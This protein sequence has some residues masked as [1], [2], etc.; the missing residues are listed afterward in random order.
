MEV[1]AMMADH[2]S[3]LFAQEVLP[4]RLGP[5]LAAWTRGAIE[6]ILGW[7]EVAR[8]RRSLLTLNEHMLKDIG[9]TRAD[10][11]REASRP[12]WD[13]GQERWRDWQ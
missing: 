9:I 2:R 10:A 6:R 7:Q 13:P 1:L 8:Q 3:E 12:F 5:R 11:L 4:R